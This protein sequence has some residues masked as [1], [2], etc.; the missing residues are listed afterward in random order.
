VVVCA[1]SA[2]AA[3]G[4]AGARGAA[5]PG[6]DEENVV[7]WML[8]GLLPGIAVV[9]LVGC[10]TYTAR[11]LDL[12]AHRE[13]WR[14]RSPGD[15]GVAAFAARLARDEGAGG[16]AFDVA[17]GLSLREGEAV[18][19][20]FNP[21]LRLARVR[22]EGAA[23]SAEFAGLWEDPELGVDAE[24]VIESVPDPWVVGATIGITI[25]VS[26]RLG[27]EKSRADAEHGA[28]LRRLA[29]EEWATRVALRSAWLEWSAQVV[30]AEL[31]RELLGR[32]E[33]VVS[34]AERLETAGELSRTEA[35]LFRIERSMRRSEQRAAEAA[36]RELGLALRALMG[37][38]PG[39]PV[40]LVPAPLA[41]EPAAAGG[42]IGERNPTLAALRAEYAA[43]EE[44]LRLAIREQYPDITIGPGFGVDEGDERVLLGVSLPVPLW[45][46][47][48]RAIAEAGAERE[49]ARAA[50]ETEYERVA[51]AVAAAEA[52]REA[53][54][55][56]REALEA[57]IVP[58][59]EEQDAENVRIAELGEVDTLLLLES[60]TRLYE[61]KTA[62]ID[63]RLAE[64]LA[65]VR[66]EELTGPSALGD[67]AQMEGAEE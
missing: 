16:G 40:E 34:V 13:A 44:G 1:R 42:E 6:T 31:G 41:F 67:G 64:A 54:R 24:R 55:E 21:D 3:P 58:M 5:V 61:T 18:A 39:A 7:R 63:G 32:L 15:E 23:A 47:N 30:R 62:L 9:L 46:R 14:A 12:A 2:C 4:G 27:V 35:R 8:R 52:R 38:A 11:P 50:F 17:D 59:V 19:L 26:G 48:R 36:E 60:L 45:N 56:Q 37:L 66:L 10:E 22:A 57:E 65:G 20:F 29:A 51:A 49:L 43:A 25:P 28:A 33:G 53:A